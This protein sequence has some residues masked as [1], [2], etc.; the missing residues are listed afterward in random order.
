MISA[1]RPLPQ[2]LVRARSRGLARADAEG[3]LVCL[4]AP[5]HPE[6]ALSLALVQHLADDLPDVEFTLE[7]RAA[8][9]VLWICG[10]ER[11][12]AELIRFLR[13]KHPH[14]K[15]LVTA[16]APEELWSAEVLAAGADDVLA[17]PVEL[18]VLSR[19]L[20]RPT[21]RRRA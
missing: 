18:A 10:Y 8:V 11:G 16:K 7:E 17:W 6:R 4:L 21:L 2:S 14:A 20:R 5:L 3:R 15:L 9:D 12:Q 1:R 13:L 19:A